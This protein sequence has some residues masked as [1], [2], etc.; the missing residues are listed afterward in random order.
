M[1]SY[2]FF[3]GTNYDVFLLKIHKVYAILISVIIMKKS[4]IP[5]IITVLA[6]TAAGILSVYTATYSL[7]GHMSYVKTQCISY[8][9]GIVSALIISRFNFRIF[10]TVGK[11]LFVLNIGLLASTLIFGTGFE[12]VGGKSWIS[13]GGFSFQPS[14][15]VKPLF[16]LSFA[17]QL[18]SE[19]SIN[20]FKALIQNLI[21][22][23][24]IIA[25]ICLQP[26]FG[27]ATVFIFITIVMLFVW[28]VPYKFF[29]G[30]IAFFS[31]LLPLLWF[32]LKDYQKNRII[33]FLNPE[34]DPSGSGY[35]VIQ[36]KIALGSGRL[37]GQG[38][39][40]GNLTQANLLPS[41][42]TDFIFSVIGEESGLLGCVVTALLLMGV[43]L[44]F[45][46]CA[47]RTKNSF[48]KLASTGLCAM[49]LFHTFINIGMCMGLMP[50]TGIPL[51]FI[52]Y[53]GTSV[54]S[55]FICV[56]LILSFK[57]QQ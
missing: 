55:V 40:K 31:A 51:P 7:D 8:A 15:L 57:R 42:H 19:D 24:I 36:S 1:L 56:G 37:F 4:C 43:I 26:D 27:T 48:I 12:E 14:E 34:T 21:H 5:L 16:V 41:K 10:D 53:G 30:G 2:Y 46:R 29:A 32:S 25:L 20:S 50:V 22:P 47:L 3:H 18:A 28:G 52:S 33:V 49:L 45:L 38:F 11:L 13:I 23:V 9:I 35:N 6:L 44:S 54:I 39:L 17:S